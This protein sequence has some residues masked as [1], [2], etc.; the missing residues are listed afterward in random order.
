MTTRYEFLSARA[1]ALNLLELAESGVVGIEPETLKWAARCA[2]NDNAPRRQATQE[3]RIIEVLRESGTSGML[4]AEIRERLELNADA[5]ATCLWSMVKRDRIARFTAPG[6]S[7]YFADEAQLVEATPR[8]L[9]EENRRR[10]RKMPPS[11]PP[12]RVRLSLRTEGWKQPRLF[13]EL[14]IVRDQG[15]IDIDSLPPTVR[16]VRAPPLP[17]NPRYSAGALSSGEWLSGWQVK[18]A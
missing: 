13:A 6:R 4:A 15:V 18:L 17:T 5:L 14:R 16:V 7:R 9:E 2:A 10:V 3:E 12:P 8:L 11:K 1:A